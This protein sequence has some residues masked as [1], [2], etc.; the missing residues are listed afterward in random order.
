MDSRKVYLLWGLGVAGVGL[1]L[2]LCA[3]GVLVLAITG[4]LP[5]SPWNRG[6]KKYR[7]RIERSWGFIVDDTLDP[8]Y[9]SRPWRFPEVSLEI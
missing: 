4:L 3:S 1:V 7:R 8:H 9:R 2:G 6:R 5:M